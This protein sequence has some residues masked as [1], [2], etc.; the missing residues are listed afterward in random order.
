M[1]ELK[2]NFALW[3]FLQQAA[4][5]APVEVKSDSTDATSESTTASVNS[6]D[7]EDS[8][9]DDDDEEEAEESVSKIQCSVCFLLLFF[10]VSGF[11]LGVNLS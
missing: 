11:D 8:D 2:F 9:D 4:A 7:S 6:N 3:L 5:E 1:G 10:H